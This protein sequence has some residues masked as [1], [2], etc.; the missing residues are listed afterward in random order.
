MVEQRK[1]HLIH[2]CVVIAGLL[3]FSWHRAALCALPPPSAESRES[4]SSAG[5]AGASQSSS[6]KPATDSVFVLPPVQIGGRISYDIRS[7]TSEGKKAVQHGVTSTIGAK[8]GTYIW[9]PWFAQLDGELGLNIL[10]RKSDVTDPSVGNAFGLGNSG[11][12]TSKNLVTTGSLQ[13]NVLQHSRFPFLAFFRKT[14]NRISGSLSSMSDYAGRSFGFTQGFGSGFG[15]GSL[16][17]ERNEQTMTGSGET[18]QD[19]LRLALSTSLSETQNVQINVLRTDN[20][21][22][23]TSERA[24]QTSVSV[25][26]RYTPGHEFHVDTLANASR[27]A[28]E[29]KHGHTTGDIVQVS[30]FGTW[31]PEEGPL[32]MT[33][34][35]RLLALENSFG[36]NLADGADF[37]MRS[38]SANVNVGAAYDISEALR[39]TAGVNFNTTGGAGPSKNTVS[40]SAGITYQP[41][42]KEIG[43]YRYSWSAATS[44]VHATDGDEQKSSLTMQV[45]HVLSRTIRL[46]R[47][48]TLVMSAN[49]TLSSTARSGDKPVQWLTHTGSLSWN[50]SFK[51][52]MAYASVNVSDS[53]ALGAEQGTFQLINFQ[54][55]SN[56]NTGRYSSLTGNLTI[57]A[58]RQEMESYFSA[59]RPYSSIETG[60]VTTSSGSINYQ[61]QRAFGV[62]RLRFRSELRLNSEALLPVLGGPQDSETASWTNHLDYTIG[63]LQLR[64]DARIAKVAGRNNRSIMFSA[65][66]SFGNF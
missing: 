8:T 50:S 34:G 17:W 42:A 44:A 55:S 33:G 64:A 12:L 19:N 47:S 7:E 37:R 58:I 14:D 13:L 22:D 4:G 63:L 36:S 16:G 21:H 20:R 43:D 5:P 40:E 35:A 27:S 15:V 41:A 38:H 52:G 3:P 28:Y 11:T 56:L 57:Q 39:A 25:Q 9:E 26:H 53:R 45:G 31:R 10:R 54:L 60:F 29:L 18:S 1:K 65:T 30:T 46:K 49:Q 32:T 59:G 23:S 66:R 24:V 2:S 62:P 48:E 6:G 61:H 51:D